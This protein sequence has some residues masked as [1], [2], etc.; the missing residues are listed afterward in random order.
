MQSYELISLDIWDTIL[1]RDCHPDAIKV[2]T[3]TVLLEQRGDLLKEEYRSAR[4]LF[5]LRQTVERDL[6]QQSTAQGFDDEYEI[7]AVF[8]EVLVRAFLER[9]PRGGGTR[10][11]EAAHLLRSR[12]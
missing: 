9:A 6:G 1:R 10:R 2:E 4:A 11:R 5:R 12:H 7:H 8:R 3:A